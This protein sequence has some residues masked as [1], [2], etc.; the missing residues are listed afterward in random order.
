ME[1]ERRKYRRLSVT[2]LAFAVF[3]PNYSKLGKITDISKGG[4]AIEYVAEEV[5]NDGSS[6]IDIF[7]AG[8][9]LYMA[10]IPIK[11]IHDIRCQKPTK[12]ISSIK[13]RRCG[14]Q[15]GELTQEQEAQ[16]DFFLE[17]HTS[18]KPDPTNSALMRKTAKRKTMWTEMGF[19]S[20]KA[21]ALPG[22]RLSKAGACIT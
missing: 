10:G 15:F 2:D 18:K 16:L 1:R 21:K 8:G 14:L 17:N 12:M 6:H 22:P 20:H 5:L 19:H 13:V 3:M 7:F 4:L 9:G 11:T